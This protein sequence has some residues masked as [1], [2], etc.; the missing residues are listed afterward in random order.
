V[1]QYV[2]RWS[3]DF[4][5]RDIPPCELRLLIILHF[6]MAFPSFPKFW[7]LYDLYVFILCFICS[8]YF[9]NGKAMGEYRQ[10]RT[11]GNLGK[12]KIC[13]EAYIFMKSVYIFTRVSWNA[14]GIFHSV[15]IVEFMRHPTV[16]GLVPT[17]QVQDD[18]T[19]PKSSTS[20]LSVPLMH[21]DQHLNLFDA[22]CIFFITLT[23]YAFAF[24]FLS[25]SSF[26]KQI[27]F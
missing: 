5:S 14:A 6:L 22:L 2:C 15:F 1:R 4:K 11:S 16:T 27:N 13:F 7:I 8:I 17:P 25:H 24:A 20:W 23:E 18:L 3:L 10:G 21:M 12:Y 19:K 26:S 9:K